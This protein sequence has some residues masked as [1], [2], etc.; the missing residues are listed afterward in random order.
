MSQT[1]IALI[2]FNIFILAMLAL[3][4]GVFHR[5]GKVVSIKESLVWSVIWTLLALVFNVG[6]YFWQGSQNALN[7]F[8]GYLIER[9]LSIDNLFVFLMIFTYFR[10]PAQYQHSV[11]L[12]GILGALVMRAI[13]IATGITL[14]EKFHW[15]IYMFG[16]FLVLTGIRMAVGKDK[17]IHPERNLVLRIFRRLVPVTKR[18]KRGKFF[19]H[20]GIRIWAT[21]LFIVLLVIETSDVIFAV[22]SIP[23]IL[24]ITT[25]P[26][27]VYS[28][29][30]FALL[31]LR[32]LYFALAGIMQIF[33]YLHY[34]LAVILVFI[35]TK[36]LVS[37][38]VHIPVSIALSV[39]GVV[40]VASIA[41][42]AVLPQRRE[43][44]LVAADDARTRNANPSQRK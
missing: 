29:N 18:Y 43:S 4:L 5:T 35:G 14:I 34:G 19:V 39:V 10:V 44:A 32:A 16:G 21:P 31:G 24:A 2:V 20:R 3:D 28:S 17:E 1:T 8:T 11:L 23:A 12:W 36:M 30:V 7:F 27:I 15:A 41:A 26:F 37:D 42:S 40:L 22:D 9:S 13:F 38:L 33:H 25:D 6:I